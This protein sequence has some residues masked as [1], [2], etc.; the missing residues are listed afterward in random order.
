MSSPSGNFS[1]DGKHYINVSKDN[2]LQL[3]DTESSKSKR[4]YVEKQHLAHSYLSFAW[5]QKN[6]ELG[7][8]AVGASDGTVLVWDLGRGV[9]VKT[10]GQPNGTIPLSMVYSSD[11]DRLYVGSTT[12]SIVAY[13][14]ES[15]NQISELQA[16]KKGPIIVRKNPVDDVIA[17]AR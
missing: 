11:G 6:G 3:W 5:N 4:S 9:V 10:V 2:R 13:D 8:Y 1:Q 14:V 15:G 17:A 12:S 7:T 16:G